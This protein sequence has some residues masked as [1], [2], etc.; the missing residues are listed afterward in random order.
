MSAHSDEA[1]GGQA[2]RG[3]QEA[4]EVVLLLVLQLIRVEGQ[5]VLDAGGVERNDC[6]AILHCAR[7]RVDSGILQT[8]IH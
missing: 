3:P 1:N 4:L 5:S 8:G 7:L 6:A 2:K